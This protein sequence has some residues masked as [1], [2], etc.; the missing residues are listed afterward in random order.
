M[1]E[2]G[3]G[4]RGGEDEKTPLIFP[5]SRKNGEKQGEE[6]QGTDKRECGGLR[7]GCSRSS[8]SER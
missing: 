1:S 4:R 2:C 3:S 8:Q 5:V 7:R 6:V